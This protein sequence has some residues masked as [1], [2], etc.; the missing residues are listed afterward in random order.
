MEKFT[1]FALDLMLPPN[2]VAGIDGTLSAEAT[3]GALDFV[4]P[5]VIGDGAPCDACH[6]LDPAQGFFG[7]GGE[8]SFENEPQNFKI[9]HLRNAY[10][11]IGMFGTFTLNVPPPDPPLGDQ[12]RGFGF[13]HDGTIGT[14][15]TFLEEG[16]FNLT[17]TQ[18]RNLEAFMLAFPTD[19]APVVGQQMN[20]GPGTFTDVAVNGR[21][22]VLDTR[23]GTTFTS[24]VLGGVVTECDVIVNTVESTS[25]RGYVRLASGLYRPDDGSAD[26]MESVLRDKA[27]PNGAA[28]DLVYTCV[29]P[30]S[31]TRMGIDR[32]LDSVHDGL[33]NCP[34]WPNA[35]ALGTCTAGDSALLASRCTSSAECG[36]GGF[37]SLAQE[38]GDSDG[39]GDA[40]ETVLLPE[41]GRGTLLL[42]GVGLLVALN[43]ARCYR[44]VRA[45]R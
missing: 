38:D 5:L 18:S 7:A 11:K 45:H 31:G 10:Q 29:P 8:Q 42:F 28:Q 13:L 20:I 14:L 3:Q 43:T 23:A 37:C 27:D 35:A 15:F 30:G 36:T 33:D 4:D 44:E 26:L 1:D 9:A 39:T 32:D 34:A 6:L 12:V 40:C 17:P 41:P 25:Q 19:V 16:P 22:G 24:L 2:P 21:I